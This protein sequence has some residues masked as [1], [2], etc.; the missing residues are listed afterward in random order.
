MKESEKIKKIID[1]LVS[2]MASMGGSATDRAEEQYRTLEEGYKAAI[3]IER[4]D[5]LNKTNKKS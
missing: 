4:K 1:D 5:N 2:H 3:E